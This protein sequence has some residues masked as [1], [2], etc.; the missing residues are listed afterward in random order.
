MLS[1]V[2]NTPAPLKIFNLWPSV[3]P[4]S[5]PPQSVTR[6]KKLASSPFFL[7]YLS[8]SLRTWARRSMDRTSVSGTDDVGSIPTGPTSLFM[9][10]VAVHQR[11]QFLFS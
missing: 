9:L 11:L 8:R 4:V 2:A 3:F 10:Q 6:I 5:F 1:Q 7:F